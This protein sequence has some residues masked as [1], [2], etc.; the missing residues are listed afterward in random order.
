[1]NKAIICA[2]ILT[3]GTVFSCHSLENSRWSKKSRASKY[4]T[5]ATEYAIAEEPEKSIQYSLKAIKLGSNDA[6][7]Y[8]LLG[9]SYS[10]LRE[11]D[12]A[13]FYFNKYLEINPKGPGY[14]FDN[15]AIYSELGVAYMLKGQ[16]A[17]AAQNFKKYLSLGPPD[18]D[19]NQIDDLNKMIKELE[20]NPNKK[21][22]PFSYPLF[23]IF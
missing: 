19:Q 15:I 21:L 2:L 8:I 14:E 3:S 13:L 17:E 12:K 1:M 23:K 11:P 7:Q 4:G 20:D 5:M 22:D 9:L 6:G 16:N 18:L 10:E